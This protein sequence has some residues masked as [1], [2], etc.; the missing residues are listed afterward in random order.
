STVA[1]AAQGDSL[2]RQP[3]VSIV[4]PYFD[5]PQFLLEAVESIERQT[6][7]HLETI[8][9]DDCSPEPA[10]SEILSNC[11]LPGLT[12]VRHDQNQGMAQAR[13]S[14]V[15]RSSGELI[16]PLDCDDFIDRSYLSTAVAALNQ[17]ELG[18]VYTQVQVFGDLDLVWI[19]EMTM[20]NVMCGLPGP[21]TF[22]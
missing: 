18:G 12:V 22:L 15:A 10:A 16:L 5:R 1:E 6:Y 13:N 20:L 19:P 2:V 21:S 8:V 17:K 4:I 9:V 7:Q 3:L 11:S 14:G